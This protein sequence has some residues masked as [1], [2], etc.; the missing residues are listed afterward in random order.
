[1]AIEVFNRVEKKYFLD[2][3]Q[4]NEL[5]KRL[6]EYMNPDAYCTDGQFY[7]INNIYFDTDTD[8]LIRTSIEKPVYKGKLRMRSYGVPKSDSLVF[9]EIKKKGRIFAPI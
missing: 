3:K 9:L 7:S 8:E 5:T 4:F 1:M 2:T 6:Q